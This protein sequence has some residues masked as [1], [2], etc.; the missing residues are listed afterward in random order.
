M[1]T[2]LL[3][4]RDSAA[5]RKPATSESIFSTLPANGRSMK[6][7]LISSEKVKAR[8]GECPKSRRNLSA[9]ETIDLAKSLS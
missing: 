7:R 2:S 3:S 8:M 4:S 5:E 1:E 9:E 6:T